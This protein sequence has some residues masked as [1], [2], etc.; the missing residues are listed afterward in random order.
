M[1]T[2]IAEPLN[3]G[4]RIDVF[5][6]NKLGFTRSKVKKLIDD[7]NVTIGGALVKAN[8]LISGS[9]EISVV[10]PTPVS[11]KAVPE[12]IPIDIIYSDEDIAVINKPQGI[13]VHAGAGIHSGTLVNALLYS[14]D[15]LS[16]V[17][18]VIRPGIV[19]RIDKDTSGL[20]VVAKNDMAHLSLSKQISEKTCRRN[21]LALVEGVVKEDSGKIDTFFGRH[22]TDRKKMAV[23]SSGSR[24]AVTL[25]TVRERYEKYTLVEFELKTGRT[26]QIRVHAKYIGHPIV[27]D[28]TYGYEKQKFNLSGQ[29]LHAYKLKLV[30]P[31]TGEEMTFTAPLPDY[32]ENVLTKLRVLVDSHK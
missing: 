30:H 7:G 12:N 24:R 32:F 9:E 27:G 2:V 13:A 16:G 10:V 4:E 23:L 29:L 15:H 6:A 28:K 8:R 17:G 14:L 5:L 19:H 25:F 18:G 1:T 26:H 11:S 20:L 22:K 31:R 3:K 21:Y